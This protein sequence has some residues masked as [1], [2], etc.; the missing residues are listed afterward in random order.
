MFLI[1]CY[2][3]GYCRCLSCNILSVTVFYNHKVKSSPNSGLQYFS[4][5][6]AKLFNPLH[7]SVENF[8][9]VQ[10][11]FHITT[12]QEF[13]NFWS[14]DMGGNASMDWVLLIMFLYIKLVINL[15]Y[16]CT[17]F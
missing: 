10:G 15:S 8:S 2:K 17:V 9:S 3:N 11:F 6:A 1:K 4:F 13:C 12:G 16:C 14:I 7:Y 5:V